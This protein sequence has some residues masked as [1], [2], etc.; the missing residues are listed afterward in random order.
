MKI[1]LERMKS[2]DMRSTRQLARGEVVETAVDISVDGIEHRFTVYVKANVQRSFDASLIYCDAKLE[3]LLRFEPA[4]LNLVC[5][6]VGKYR[7]GEEI[8]LPLVLVDST[9]PDGE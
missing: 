1:R 5:S 6:L 7:R 4:A 2:S 9:S 8:G 3:D